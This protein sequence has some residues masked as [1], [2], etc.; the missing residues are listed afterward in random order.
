MPPNTQSQLTSLL[1]NTVLARL[2]RLRI[3]TSRRF[4]DRRRGENLAGRSGASNEFSDYRDYVEGDDV[5]FVD[6]NIFARLHRPYMKLYR[7]EEEMHVAILVDASNSMRFEGKLARARQLAAA[8]GV[9]GLLGT[10]RVSVHVL[11]T[12]GDAPTSLPPSRGRASMM[13]LFAFLEWIQEGGDQ[14]LDGGVDQFLKRHTGRG[15]TVLLSDFLTAG[16]LHRT[17]NRLFSAGQEVFAVQILG[18]TE[19][20]PEVSGDSR[21]VDSETEQTLDVSCNADLLQLYHEYRLGL[22]HELGELL[23]QRGGRF[24][25]TG[26]SD[27]LEEILFG[28][29]RRGGW[30]Q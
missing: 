1:D 15:V 6:W 16:D 11:N 19:I 29:M 20:A 18:P 9:M 24:L 12:R 28:Q 10:E 23:R 5:R 3:N 4:T 2:Q 21:F 14:T 25:F 8:F 27:P 13:K 30:L 7:E 17:F 22:K 26:A